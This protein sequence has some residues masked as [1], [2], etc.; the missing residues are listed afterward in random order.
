MWGPLHYEVGH[1]VITASPRFTHFSAKTYV[2]T[3]IPLLLSLY[4][5]SALYLAPCLLSLPSH[6]VPTIIVIT[7]D[8]LKLFFGIHVLVL[9]CHAN[10]NNRANYFYS[11]FVVREAPGGSVHNP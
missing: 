4:G 5:F 6:G 7:L 11:S 1:P 8:V 9:H 3:I 10:R 2:I